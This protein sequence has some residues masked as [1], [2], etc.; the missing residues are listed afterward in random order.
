MVLFPAQEVE[1]EDAGR[2]M[3]FCNRHTSPVRSRR[4]TERSRR[5]TDFPIRPVL[6]AVWDWDGLGNP[7]YKRN[8]DARRGFTAVE[9]IIALLLIVA[10]LGLAMPAILAPLGRTEL[11]DAGKQ[12]RSAL[13]QTRTTAIESG[14]PHEFRF[15]LGGAR[16]EIGPRLSAAGDAS[17]ASAALSAAQTGPI[18]PARGPGGEA[19]VLPTIEDELPHGVVFAL[20]TNDY[21]D[22]DADFGPALDTES[23]IA[24]A[25]YSP[26]SI[27]FY[28]N[29]RASDERIRLLGPNHF[30]L[31]VMLRGLTGTATV[32][33]PVRQEDARRSAD[34]ASPTENDLP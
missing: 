6:R 4:R 21:A 7:C 18:D 34:S 24:A 14:V 11:E 12:V 26:V 25:E 30:L 28:P 20:L 3:V 23:A 33:E 29:G 5:R 8:R 22:A 1:G 31:D 19:D 17:S 13:A 10:A 9:L 16:W 2:K 32:G 15:Q 27:I